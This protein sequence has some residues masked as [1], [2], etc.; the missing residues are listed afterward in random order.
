[1]KKEKNIPIR[2]LLW[3]QKKLLL[4]KQEQLTQVI[5]TLDEV[6][7]NC[8]DWDIELSELSGLIKLVTGNGKA[9]RNFD[10]WEHFG[11]RLQS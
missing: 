7:E 3:E 6:A 1:M 5:R 9:Q 11:I 10:T 2:E 8:E 4:R